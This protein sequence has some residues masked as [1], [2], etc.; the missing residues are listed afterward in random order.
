MSDELIKN[1]LRQSPV[2]ATDAN[3]KDLV[4]VYIEENENDF[5]KIGEWNVSQVTMM[6][7]LFAEYDEFN[8][9]ISGWDVSKV[10]NMSGMFSE[11][12]NFNQDIS[13]WNV[14]N[15]KDMSY[16]FDAAKSFNVNISG[17]NV[18]NVVI[19][20]RTGAVK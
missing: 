20:F 19:Q 14:S 9:D 10:E 17:W 2:M 5:I 1:Q 4:R 13:K 3:I 8:E 7:E 11:T 16:M 18:S 6:S 15:V 12:N